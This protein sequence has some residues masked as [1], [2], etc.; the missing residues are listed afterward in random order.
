MDQPAVGAEEVGLIAAN[1]AAHAAAGVIAALPRAQRGDD[2]VAAL[3]GALADDTTRW[4]RPA[5]DWSDR[6]TGSLR[7]AWSAG[8]ARVGRERGAPVPQWTAWWQDAVRLVAHGKPSNLAADPEVWRLAAAPGVV[9]VVVA[10]T[11]LNATPEWHWPLRLAVAPTGLGR[12]RRAAIA[13]R[14]HHA[15]LFDHNVDVVVVGEDVSD[16]GILV[17]DVDDLPWLASVRG[18][19]AS[20]LVVV[21]DA[22]LG[23]VHNLAMA[24]DVSAWSLLAIPAARETDWLIEVLFNLCHDAPIDAALFQRP[25]RWCRGVAGA[26]LRLVAHPNLLARARISP[27][28]RTMVRHARGRPQDVPSARIR[29]DQFPAW[30]LGLGAMPGLN[31]KRGADVRDVLARASPHVETVMFDREGGG[32]TATAVLSRA[33][34][35]SPAEPAPRSR[36]TIQAQLRDPTTGERRNKSLRPNTV[37]ELAVRVGPGDSGWLQAETAFPE[38]D[39]KWDERTGG[40]LFEIVANQWVVGALRSQRQITFVPRTGTSPAVSFDVVAGDAGQ[41]VVVSIL[42]RHEGRQLQEAALTGPVAA[43]DEAA[44]GEALRLR[45]AVV[46]SETLTASAGSHGR[47]G[48]L[49][50]TAIGHVAMTRR[51]RARPVEI[52]GL[53]AVAGE[54]RLTLA[55]ASIGGLS[56]AATWNA[57]WRNLARQGDELRGLFADQIGSTFDAARR[58]Q[59][60]S[61][62]VDAI[63]PLEFVYDGG[64]PSARSRPC[65]GWE[66]ALRT[67]RCPSCRGRRPVHEAAETVCPQRF[68]GLSKIVERHVQQSGGNAEN[69]FTSEPVGERNRLR[70]LTSVLFGASDRANERERDTVS[71]VTATLAA[72]GLKV[73][74]ARTW[75][76]WRR[77]VAGEAPPLLLALAH[78]DGQVAG[79]GPQRLV[80]GRSSSLPATSIDAT[81]VSGSSEIGPVVL[82]L[83]CDTTDVS[84]PSR[85][86]TAAFRRGHASV[87]VGTLAPVYGGDA[88]NA[89][90]AMVGELVAA[91]P[92]RADQ[93]LGKVVRDVRRRLVANRIP[94]ALALTA[95]GDADWLLPHEGA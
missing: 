49:T 95:Y 93:S 37:H 21:G 77:R 17:L 53:L 91:K 30:S 40:A 59:I 14:R 41:S 23:A 71:K 57:F 38:A 46:V 76:T 79:R 87:V 51:G 22:D 3:A 10:D 26:R 86:F 88:A 50:S 74:S 29:L 52:Q 27:V 94:F 60:V 47:G 20:V 82:L 16:A 4:V 5:T 78:N 64:R 7:R 85:G 73:E 65:A 56:T 55:E 18:L 61:R 66:R 84:T 6:P 12:A 11:G 90:A 35:G 1:P 43:A 80:I 33:I 34:R 36:R 68:W 69:L 89:A 81:Y 58:I 9:S 63:V 31:T 2:P 15:S 67:G 92:R 45:T 54:L 62:D 8:L 24:L 70:A 44:A 72:L 42:V 25:D 28:L 75:K 32:A 83:G 13:E 48:V 19:G 39:V